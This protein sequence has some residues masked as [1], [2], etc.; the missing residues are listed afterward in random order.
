MAAYP[1]SGTPAPGDLTGW[2]FTPVPE[3]ELNQAARR[4]LAFRLGEPD[5]AR[6]IES[7]P[8]PV[9]EAA[10]GELCRIRNGCSDAGAIA[11]YHSRRTGA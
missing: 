4:V 2:Q 11:W 7:R 5:L 6:Q 1:A 8:C 3:G 9:C 10:A